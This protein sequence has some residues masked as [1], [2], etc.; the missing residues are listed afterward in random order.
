MGTKHG[1]P[2]WNCRC[3][4]KANFGTRP[5]CRN[6]QCG[7]E[8]PKRIL[9]LQAE[10]GIQPG[11]TPAT[12][13]PTTPRANLTGAAEL[14]GLRPGG[15]PRQTGINSPNPAAQNGAWGT[16][17]AA[18][19]VHWGPTEQGDT[20][21]PTDP[22]ED[23]AKLRKDLSALK[24]ILQT[25]RNTGGP[26]EMVE[27]LELRIAKTQSKLD[28]L[29]PM[30]AR[31]QSML[32]RK[33][34]LTSK[35]A[36]A[37][38]R[39]AKAQAELDAALAEQETTKESLGKVEEE[40]E[41]ALKEQSKDKPTAVVP[42][43]EDWLVNKAFGDGTD[44][45][46]RNR[47]LAALKAWGIEALQAQ[48]RYHLLHPPPP[49]PKPDPGSA[50]AKRIAAQEHSKKLKAAAE[51]ADRHAKAAE[52]AEKAEEDAKKA[53]AAADKAKAEAEGKGADS[54]EQKRAKEAAEAAVESI[55][56]KA[57]TAKLQEDAAEEL[58]KM[59]V[60]SDEATGSGNDKTAEQA[61]SGAVA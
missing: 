43:D 41:Q 5:T 9:K 30:D 10:K 33:K 13:P 12:T 50:A 14:G 2:N 37:D 29:R 38:A 17:N 36:A 21:A 39:V 53:Q 24:Q 25:T 44:P 59:E 22:G 31:L 20:P 6:P 54:P 51:A 28:S 40:L 56:K 7:A 60:D 34:G 8:A 15:T 35:L 23:P 48:E 27:D 58:A 57:R 1:I 61:P 45:E 3:G 47:A 26:P 11:G 19:R 32:D 52:E 55:A 18:R 4:T 49:A 16:V 46:E 42:K